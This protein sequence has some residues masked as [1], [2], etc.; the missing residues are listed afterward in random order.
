MS[1]FLFILY[2]VCKLCIPSRKN[3]LELFSFSGTK[4]TKLVSAHP[5]KEK[6]K[7]GSN[8]LTFNDSILLLVSFVL[9]WKYDQY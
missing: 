5:G 7:S 6:E 4:T 9:I 1:I 3:K 8:A 2:V